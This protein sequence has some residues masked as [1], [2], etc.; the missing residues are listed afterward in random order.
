MLYFSFVPKDMICNMVE[1]NIST[2]LKSGLE[3]PEKWQKKIMKL[4][5]CITLIIKFVI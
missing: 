1:E 5:Y 2:C 4:I 3:K